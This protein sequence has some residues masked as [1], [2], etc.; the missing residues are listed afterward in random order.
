MLVVIN[1]VA[2]EI[3]QGSRDHPDVRDAVDGGAD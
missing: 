1:K 3:A 2:E